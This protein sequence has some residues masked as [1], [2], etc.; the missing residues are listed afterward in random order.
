M[1]VIKKKGVFMNALDIPALDI[2]I[3]FIKL[4]K[5]SGT[6]M[7]VN[8]DAIAMIVPD[9][10]SARLYL[11]YGI[12]RGGNTGYGFYETS[13]LTQESYQEVVDAINNVKLKHL[14]VK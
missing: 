4:H 3:G 9:G 14:F 13:F 8:V 6:I 5:T 7:I 2:P 12:A 1:N 10:S 11:S